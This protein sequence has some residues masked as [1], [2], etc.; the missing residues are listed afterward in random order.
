M[1]K[2]YL[3]KLVELVAIY[4][5]CQVAMWINIQLSCSIVALFG[6]IGRGLKG[7]LL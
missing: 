7:H 1:R 3:I 5:N 6:R 2:S 4:L